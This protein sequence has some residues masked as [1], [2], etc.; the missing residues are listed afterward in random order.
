MLELNA[1]PQGSTWLLGEIERAEG[2]APLLLG[3][4]ACLGLWARSHA[5]RTGVHIVRYSAW[6]ANARLLD[7][8]RSLQGRHV[9]TVPGIRCGALFE[10]EARVRDDLPVVEGADIVA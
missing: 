4:G 3:I 7:F 9:R 2:R 6:A 8:Y 1:R 10:D 5:G